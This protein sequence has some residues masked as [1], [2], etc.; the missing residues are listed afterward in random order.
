M[1]DKITAPNKFYINRSEL[2]ERYD[3]L[4]YKLKE[5]VLK[6]FRFPLEKIGNS[7]FV[8]DGDHD[9]LPENAVTTGTSGRRYL[10]AQDLKSNRIVEENPVYVTEAYFQGVKRC[11]IHPGDL[12]FSIM[13]SIGSTAIVPDDYPVCTAN[14]AIGI[15]RT[16]S[17][18]KLLPTYLQAILNTNIGSSILEIEKRGGIQ[19]RL[20]I[21]DIIGLR[22]PAP[23][24]EI[25]LKIAEIYQDGLDIK[26]RK[27]LKAKELLSN[28]DSYILEKLG[29]SLPKKTIDLA[30]RMFTVTFNEVS[31][32][33]LDPLYFKNKATVQSEIYDS[34]LLNSIANIEKGQSI[35]KEKI[36]IGN[37][38][39]IAGGQTSPYSHSDFNF[40]GDVIT[41]S[42]SG[43]YSGY[44]WYHNYPIFASDCTV[45]RSKNN[46]YISTEFIYHVMKALQTEIYKFQQGAGQPHVYARDL[47]KLLIPVPPRFKQKEMLKHINDTHTQVKAYQNDATSMFE[48]AKIQIE[49]MILE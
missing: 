47:G 41:V 46:N 49:K 44:V 4:Y 25:Q 24:F 20:N 27:E 14:R 28:T 37:Y 45:I 42:A 11:H 10:R 26:E 39:V 30:S 8:K 35:T 43:A 36:S 23:P 32:I 7:F 19:Q 29:L 12:L 31:G 9:K 1:S 15:L 17:T 2:D 21:A 33:R 40:E 22:L 18:G 6:K 48:N 3:V 34:H 5:S 13:A 38:P 16:K